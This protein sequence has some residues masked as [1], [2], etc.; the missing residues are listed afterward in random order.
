MVASR[1]YRVYIRLV[2]DPGAERALDYDVVL[3]GAELGSGCISIN[4]ARHPEH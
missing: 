3:N 1:K 4:S 2:S